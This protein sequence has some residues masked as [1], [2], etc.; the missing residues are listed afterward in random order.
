MEL[1]A[2]YSTIFEANGASHLALAEKH[3]QRQAELEAGIAAAEKRIR[4]NPGNHNKLIRAWERA[5]V[6]L[7]GVIRKA[8]QAEAKHKFNLRCQAEFREDGRLQRLTELRKR[9]A[10]RKIDLLS[11]L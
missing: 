8:E 6:E 3:R 9:K 7:A 1:E 5:Q 10:Q 2:A 4:D 11:V